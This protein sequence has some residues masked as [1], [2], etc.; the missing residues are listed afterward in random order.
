M[1]EE[2]ILSSE[3]FDIILE[4]GISPDLESFQDLQIEESS[5]EVVA[6]PVPD[7]FLPNVLTPYDTL[8]IVIIGMAVC[9]AIHLAFARMAGIGE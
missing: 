3:D 5:A 4:S 7:T 8:L 6:Y 9:H 1:D 2:V